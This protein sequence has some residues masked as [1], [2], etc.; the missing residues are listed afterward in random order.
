VANSIDV[1]LGVARGDEASAIDLRITGVI[2]EGS[3]VAT[4]MCEGDEIRVGDKL[5]GSYVATDRHF[6]HARLHLQR[7]PIAHPPSSSAPPLG[8]ADDDRHL[9]PSGQ[10]IGTWELDTTHMQPSSYTLT[11]RVVDR[12]LLGG[13]TVTR[14]S[15]SVA[16][17][18]QLAPARR[19]A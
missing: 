9:N 6:L 17:D 4:A 13:S 14:W 10:V 18:F 7:T 19:A 11:L 8:I 15:G 3:S 2:R 5:L 12:T 16:I 1:E